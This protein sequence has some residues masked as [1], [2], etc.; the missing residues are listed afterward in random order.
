[1][2]LVE[3]VRGEVSLRDDADR[4]VSV[5]AGHEGRVLAG[6]APVV[7]RSAHGAESGDWSEL[8][9][10]RAED[11]PPRGIGELRAKKPGDARERDRGVRLARHHV[12][13][14]ISGN[15]ARTEIDE[16]FSNESGD[17]L[18]GIYR[19][20][21]PPDA[22]IERPRSSRRQLEEARSCADRA[23]RSGAASP[24]R[25]PLASARPR[26]TSWVSWPW[27]IRRLEWQRGVG[28]ARIFPIRRGIASVV[29]AY[30]R[31]SAST[32]PRG[33]HYPLAYDPTGSTTSRT[34]CRSPARDDPAFGL[35]PGLRDDPPTARTAVPRAWP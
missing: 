29:L 9:P 32:A 35:S 11:E 21:L 2:S 22:Q 5:A 4:N 30:R 23:G 25:E 8:A 14:R 16:T 19:M 10:A 28:S 24:E 6:R 26:P 17:E 7:A 27:K 15:V 13:V 33:V 18:E 34:S 1:M 12:K 3:V 31:R 20:P